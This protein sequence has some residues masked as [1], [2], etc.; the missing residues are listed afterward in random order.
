MAQ[1]TTTAAVETILGSNFG[2][3]P[4]GTEPS[5]QPYVDTANNV[6]DQVVTCATAKGKTLSDTTLELM[7]RW[8]SAYYY[9]HMDPLYTSRTTKDASG[10]FSDPEKRYKDAAIQLDSSGCLA[11]ILNGNPKAEIFWLGKPRSQQTD[12]TERD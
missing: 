2:N 4:D 12:Y 6:V 8:L 3:L 1:R 9:T 11:A 10:S 5:L 7:E